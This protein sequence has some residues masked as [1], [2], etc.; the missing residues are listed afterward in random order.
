ML[1]PHS[2]FAAALRPPA[3]L[4][5]LAVTKA[6]ETSLSQAAIRIQCAGRREDAR[7]CSCGWTASR[8]GAYTPTQPLECM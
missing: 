6:Y 4:R 5:R 8:G 7:H 3:D 1:T 2:A